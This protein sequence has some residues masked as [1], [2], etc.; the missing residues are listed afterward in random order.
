[1]WEAVVKRKPIRALTA[2]QVA[3]RATRMVAG[4]TRLS[5]AERIER[6]RH[7]L[8]FFCRYYLAAYFSAEPAQFHSELIE[9]VQTHDRGVAAAPR[10]HAKSTHVSFAFPLHQI[11]YSLKHFVVI[12]RE[13]DQV[14]AQ[15]VDDIRQELEE[16]ELIREDFGDLVGNRKWA[17]SEFVTS[18][19]VKVVGRGRG[20]SMRGMR[21]KQYRPDLV[22]ADD[23]EDDE[24]VENRDRRDK[25]ER[26]LKRVVLNILGPDGKF[27][28]IG[29][30]LHHDSVLV[31][32]LAQTDVYFTRVWKALTDDKPLWP[33]RWPLARL[34]AKR[35]EIGARNFETEFQNNPAN[36]EDQIF[37]PNNWK[38]FRDEDVEGELDEVAAIDP[39]I[40]QKAKN[41]DTA[42]VVIGERG[43]NYYVLRI[44]MKKLKVQQQVQLV[45]ATCREFPRIRKFAFE[46]IAYQT[47]LKQLV[48]EESGRN[49]LQIPAVAAEDLSS[50][51]IKRISTLAPMAEQGRIYFPSPSSSYWSND[52]EKCMDQFEALGCSGDSHDD[53][54]DAVERAIRL[55]RGKKGKKGRVRII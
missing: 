37:S 19:G 5:K 52:V 4:A 10:E 41:D 15:N 35:K 12:I 11:C 33:S 6:G 46:T 48:D 50:D 54:P 14:A 24:L 43:G 23:I 7:D 28:M 32:M 39:A 47:A 30:I 22:I 26:W 51:K 40:G 1:M 53:G 16:N 25:L 3:E 49:N 34:L 13:A 44:T 8:Q 2:D 36:E 27:F 9:M 31:R 21:F 29:T 42:V 17:E 55:L 38:R 18:N 45:F 20:Q